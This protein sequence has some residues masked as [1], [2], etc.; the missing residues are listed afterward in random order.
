MVAE[1]SR[2]DLHDQPIFQAHRSHLGKHLGSEE[3]TLAGIRIA[4]EDFSK[5]LFSFALAQIRRLRGRMTMVRCR[6]A[7]LTKSLSRLAHCTKIPPPRICILASL[8]PKT[9]DVFCE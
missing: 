6:A 1:T 5:Q 3:F 7:C 8:L 2:V 9:R 4:C